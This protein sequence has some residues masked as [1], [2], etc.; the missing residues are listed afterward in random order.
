MERLTQFLLI[1]AL[2]LL[3]PLAAMA[4]QVTLQYT[5]DASAATGCDHLRVYYCYGTG[6]TPHAEVHRAP[7]VAGSCAA[8]A[9]QL[10]FDLE[11]KEERIGDICFRVTVFGT[12][13]NE[14]AGDTFCVTATSGG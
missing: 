10:V 6:C 9:Q 4:A 11:I 5:G 3:L 1:S 13:K 8:A 14:T 12:N 7:A 2:A